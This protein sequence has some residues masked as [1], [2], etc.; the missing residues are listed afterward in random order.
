MK[1]IALLLL[2]SAFIFSAQGAEPNPT[3][4]SQTLLQDV[5]PTF[6]STPTETPD[7]PSPTI[8]PTPTYGP[9]AD[10]LRDVMP[11]TPV[12]V[13]YSDADSTV[14]Y[15]VWGSAMAGAGTYAMIVRYPSAEAAAEAYSYW[16]PDG[17][18]YDTEPDPSNDHYFGEGWISWLDGVRIFEVYSG[19]ASTMPPGGIPY[20]D[21]I[22]QDLHDAA[23]AHGLIQIDPTPTPTPTVTPVATPTPINADFNGDGKVDRMDLFE[24]LRQWHK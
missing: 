21:W 7:F 11:D 20:P 2:V 4:R 16:R 10:V 18:W 6:T 13:D 23:V 1:I 8:T 9:E 12:E 3:P 17:G 14:T 22:A 5:E 19:Y 24:L 15:T